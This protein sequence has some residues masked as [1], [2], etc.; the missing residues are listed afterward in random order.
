MLFSGGGRWSVPACTGQ[1]QK[2]G[3]TPTYF[4]GGCWSGFHPA[5]FP[6]HLGTISS[7]ERRGEGS[8]LVEWT[9]FG[10]LQTP[11][12][13][14]GGGGRYFMVEGLPSPSCS[15]Q[16]QHKFPVLFFTV[17]GILARM[18]VEKEPPCWEGTPSF[19]AWVLMR[20]GPGLYH[21]GAPFPPPPRVSGA[22]KSDRE[23][24]LLLLAAAGDN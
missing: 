17:P 7:M 2:A 20:A 23:L 18:V 24:A 8:H 15:H 4:Q 9:W 14:K 12:S 3:G 16:Q 21:R 11:A 19:P 6:C 1:D 13:N 10:L 5:L 22:V